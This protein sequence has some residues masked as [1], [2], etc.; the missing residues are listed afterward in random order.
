MPSIG[1]M[2]VYSSPQQFSP[3]DGH[4]NNAKV[5]DLFQNRAPNP[6]PMQ[7]PDERG[8]TG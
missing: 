2:Q 7:F 5:R 3:I 6:F 1:S 8:I 4:L